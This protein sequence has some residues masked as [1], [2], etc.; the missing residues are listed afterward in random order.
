MDGPDASYFTPTPADA[1]LPALSVQL[2]ELFPGIVPD[3]QDAMPE[4]LS[5]PEVVK[6]TGRLYQSPKSG[7]REREMLTDGG[8]ASYLMGPKVA[9]ELVLPA[10]SVHV[11]EN[12]AFVVSGPEYVVE[13]QLAIPD[14]A[15]LPPKLMPTGRLYQPF[16]SGPRLGDAPVTVGGVASRLTVMTGVL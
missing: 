5:L 15:S 10:L 14:V 6:L 4:R 2:P 16:A 12:D 3:V 1:V 13:L 9:G 11:P 8:V 7:P